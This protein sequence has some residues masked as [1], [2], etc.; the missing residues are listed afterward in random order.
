MHPQFW[1][2]N[3]KTANSA[4]RW[5]RFI[6]FF[7]TVDHSIQP[8]ERRDMGQDNSLKNRLY[9]DGLFMLFCKELIAQQL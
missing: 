8:L 3:E 6:Y 5:M 1:Q 7:M 4:K 9:F 2:E